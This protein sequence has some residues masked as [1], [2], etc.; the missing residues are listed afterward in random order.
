MGGE[1]KNVETIN[2]NTCSNEIIKSGDKMITK[3]RDYAW[4]KYLFT[5]YNSKSENIWYTIYLMFGGYKND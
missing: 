1:L 3:I 4:I 2:I 5:K